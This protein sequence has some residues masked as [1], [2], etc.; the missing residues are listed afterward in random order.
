MTY[1]ERALASE[2]TLIGVGNLADAL[3]LVN[4]ELAQTEIE[5]A[6]LVRIRGAVIGIGDSLEKLL[7][8]NN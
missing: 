2:L 1:Q 4:W 8:E 3:Q 7:A 6:E 5:D